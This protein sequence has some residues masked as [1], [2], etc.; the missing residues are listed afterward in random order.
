M[1]CKIESSNKRGAAVIS[2]RTLKE[3]YK[4]LTSNNN[5]DNKEKKKDFQSIFKFFH[6]KSFL[7]K[8]KL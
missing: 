6:F 7:K 5:I 1:D 3:V 4:Y 8:L 2:F